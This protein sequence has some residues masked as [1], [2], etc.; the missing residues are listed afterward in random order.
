MPVLRRIRHAAAMSSGARLSLVVLAVDDVVRSVRFYQ[1]A[2][3]WPQA[4]DAGIYAELE[5]PD[6]MQLGLYARAGFVR[7]TGEPAAAMP[8]HGTTSTELYLRVD[9]LD[10]ASDA[11]VRGGARCLSPAAPRS[12]GDRAAYFADPDG[13]VVVVATPA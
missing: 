13:N 8:P 9:D 3:G 10:A 12:W 4:V 1:D 2:F 11:L 5:L 6:G 7:N